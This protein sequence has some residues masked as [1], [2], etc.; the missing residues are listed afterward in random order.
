M[1]VCI[2]EIYRDRHDEMKRRDG[3]EG[4]ER[5]KTREKKKQN[6]KML[7][8]QPAHFLTLKSSSAPSLLSLSLTGPVTGPSP[9]PAREGRHPSACCAC[10][11]GFQLRQARK[12]AWFPAC[13]RLSLF[14]VC[15]F[16]LKPAGCW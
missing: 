10:F 14:K 9:P 15:L 7:S 2:K 16:R 4:K 11:I 3:D 8:F 13:L 1:Y 6:G 5:R 12:G